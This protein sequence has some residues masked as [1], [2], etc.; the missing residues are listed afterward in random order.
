M[1]YSVVSMLPTRP[2]VG[3]G[4]ACVVTY[5]TQIHRAIHRR[6]R[7]SLRTGGGRR[8]LQGSASSALGDSIGCTN[9]GCENGVESETHYNKKLGI[10]FA[11]GK[12]AL[13]REIPFGNWHSIPSSGNP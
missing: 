9:N 13:I 4:P 12:M 1:R 5:R 6:A 3:D 10:V 7:G 2:A 11:S 8:S